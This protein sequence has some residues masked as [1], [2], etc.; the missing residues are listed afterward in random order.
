M[1]VNDCASVIVKGFKK[2]KPEIAVGKGIEMN[3]LWIKRYFPKTL[4]KMAAKQYA[5]MAKNNNL[6]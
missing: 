1:N 3:A 2:G 5:K 4:F 6:R